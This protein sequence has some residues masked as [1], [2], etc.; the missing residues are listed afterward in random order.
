[1]RNAECGFISLFNADVKL[2]LKN[3]SFRIPHS[4]FR[5]PHSPFPIVAPCL[6]PSENR[7]NKEATWLLQNRDR[8]PGRTSRRRRRRGEACRRENAQGRNP[9]G[10]AGRS[11]GLREKASTITSRSGPKKSS[12]LFA[13]KT[14]AKGGASSVSRANAAAVPGTLKSG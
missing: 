11:P 4:A 8:L 3:A 5:I 1:M 13:R 7:R 12:P 10:G 6:R 9:K 14:W 2:R